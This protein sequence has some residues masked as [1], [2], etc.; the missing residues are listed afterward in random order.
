MKRRINGEQWG[1]IVTLPA[2]VAVVIAGWVVWRLGANL[3]S[4]ERRQLAWGAVGTLAWQHVRLTLICTAIV[5][6]TAVPLGVLLT[7]PKVRRFAPVVEA[8]ANAGQAAPAIGLVVLFA[9][10]LGFGLTTA[11]VAL[12]IYAFLPVLRN[13][14]AG[15]QGVDP[16]LIE[17]G[18]G[19][20]MSPWGVLARVELPL[21]LPVIMVGV[22][23]ALVL[24]VATVSV[25]TFIS[26]GGLGTLIQSGILLFRYPIL[27][28]GAV[29][30][31]VLALLVDWVGRVLEGF[32]KPKGL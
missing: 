24:V 32:V 28:S 11:V 30:V 22:R 13:T 6:C 18:R 10:W 3:D 17:A 20:G 27:V 31:A 23:T 26:A 9:M 21:A 2:I 25:A 7:R 12:S 29:L 1:M 4:I 15:L 5:V 16:T 19:M 8:L 14:M